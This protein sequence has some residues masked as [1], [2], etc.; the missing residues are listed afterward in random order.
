MKRRIYW[1]FFGGHILEV[2]SVPKKYLSGIVFDENFNKNGFLVLP[3][4]RYS[5]CFF[6]SNRDNLRKTKKFTVN[7]TLKGHIL[8]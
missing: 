2:V 5:R 3:K 8:L 4:L 6:F 7:F 1:L